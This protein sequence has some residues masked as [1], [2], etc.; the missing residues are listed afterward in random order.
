MLVIIS[1]LTDHNGLV[2]GI[3]TDMAPSMRILVE[4]VCGLAVGTTLFPSGLI[5]NSQSDKVWAFEDFSP[6]F[7]DKPQ[8]AIR[9]N[10]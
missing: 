6:A 5:M 10:E 8:Q 9:L 1:Y 4:V 7:W 2:H 3:H